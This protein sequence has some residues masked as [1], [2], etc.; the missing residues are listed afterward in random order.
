MGDL[1]LLLGV[2]FSFSFSLGQKYNNDSNEYTHPLLG[3]II[4]QNLAT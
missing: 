1:G 4:K 3:D 2:L